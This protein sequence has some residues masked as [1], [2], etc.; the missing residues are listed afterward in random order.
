MLNNWWWRYLHLT[1]NLASTDNDLDAYDS[2]IATHF[3]VSPWRS[4]VAGICTMDVADHVRLLPVSR[5]FVCVFSGCNSWLPVVQ[6]Y[7]IQ[8]QAKTEKWKWHIRFSF[9]LLLLSFPLVCLVLC[10]VVVVKPAQ[11]P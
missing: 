11:H 8:F 6:R 4:R 5:L 7:E 2:W 3:M 9:S 1:S 10:S